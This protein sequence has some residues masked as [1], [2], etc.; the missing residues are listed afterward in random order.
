MDLLSLRKR[1]VTFSGAHTYVT[2]RRS[3]GGAART[4][5]VPGKA[6][7][8]LKRRCAAISDPN[9]PA[10]GWDIFKEYQW[11]KAREAAGMENIRFH[12]LRHWCAS[13]YAMA[14]CSLRMLADLLGQRREQVLVHRWSMERRR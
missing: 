8:M 4:V 13:F 3:K 12:D 6:A 10:L 11:T 1:D 7:Q 9:A 14:G 5:P 2:F